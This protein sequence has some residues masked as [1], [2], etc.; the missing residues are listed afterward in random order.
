MAQPQTTL[1]AAITLT[2]ATSITVRDALGFASSLETNDVIQVDSEFMLVTGGLGTTSWT[3]TRG[4]ASSTAATHLNGATVSRIIRSWT[5]LTRI[6]TR[7]D[8]ATSDTTDDALLP[9]FID[10]A[11]A[12]MTRLVGLFLGPSTDTSRTYDGY[13]ARR[14]GTRLWVPGGLRSISLLEIAPQTA[15]SFTTSTATDY[16]IGPHPSDLRDGQP[17]AYV[18]LLDVTAGYGYFPKGQDNIR[19]TGAFGYA[20]PPDDLQEIA[21]ALVLAMWKARNTGGAAVGPDGTAVYPFLT[22]PQISKLDIYRYENRV[23]I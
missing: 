14:K 9:Q 18:E 11:N 7:T 22:W 10:A 13:Q 12:E 2:N 6:K 16:R 15:G 19:V 17:S 8:I 1:S 3:V 23:T 4:Y 20:A 5:D 21:D